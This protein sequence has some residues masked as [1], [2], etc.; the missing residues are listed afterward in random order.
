M[1]DTSFDAQQRFVIRDYDQQPPFASFLPGI[2]G[3]MGIPMWVFYV[4]RGQAIASFGS[5]SKDTPI[6]EFEPAN[7]AYRNVTTTGFRTFVKANGTFYEPFAPAPHTAVERTMHIGANALEL[8]EH[9]HAHG[10][11]VQVR[12]FTLTNEPFAG[13]VRQMQ[14]TNTGAAPVDVSVLDGLPAIMPFGVDNWVLKELART[15][16]AWMGVFNLEERIPFYRLRSSIGDKV[17]I[18]GYEAGHFYT[19]FTAQGRLPALVDPDVIFGPNTSL[20]QPDRFLESSLDELFKREQIAVGKTPCGFFGAER[21]LAPGDALTLYGIIGHASSLA[22]VNQ[23]AARITQPA[24]IVAQHDV[25]Q[26][27]TEELTAPIATQTGLPQFDAY[28]RQTFLDNI[29]RGGWPIRLGDPDR[30][31]VQHIY[32]RKHGDLERDYNAFYLAPEFYSQGN[33]N[34]R[35]INQNRREDVWLQPRIGAYNIRAFMNLIQA[36]G[37]NPLVINGNRFTVPPEHHAAVLAQVDDP[38][39]LEKFLTKPF[40]PGALL[41]FIAVT[42][43]ALRVPPEEFL[44]HTLGHAEHEF[45]AVFGEGYWI[46]HWTYNLDLIENYLAIFPERKTALLFEEPVYTFYDSPGVVQPRDQ[47]YVLSEGRVRQLNAV[48]EDAEKEAL[49]QS[50]QSKPHLVRADQGQGDIVYTTLITKLVSLAI[51]KFATMDPLGM[52]VEMEAGKPGW[53]DALN[54]LPGLFGSS[55][56]ET[57]ELLRLLRF[58]RT[59]LAAQD[60]HTSMT[61]PVEVHDLLRTVQQALA[62]H[63]ASA[64][65]PY[66]DTVATARE[67]YRA[68][69][70]LGFD[71][72]TV[73]MTLTDL[74]HAL[75]QLEQ[76]VQ[77]GIERATTMNDGIPPTYFTYQ[78]TGYE[79]LDDP[80][81]NPDRQCVRVTQFEVRVLPLFLEGP[82]RALKITDDHTAAQQL[83]ER[84]RTS[85]LFDHKL[86]M[87]KVNAPLGDQPTDI[88]RA[89]AFT[90]GWLENESIW[91]HMEY[92]YLLALLKAKLFEAFYADFRNVLVPFQNPT[93]YGRSPL[94]N[95]SFIVSSAHPDGTLHGRGFVARLSGS[96]VEF[97]SILHFILIGPQPFTVCDGALRLTLQPTLPGWLFDDAGE[98]TFTF[99]GG[100]AVTYI[101]PDRRDTFGSEA[102][103]PQQI[104]LQW[105]DGTTMILE[106][107]TIPAPYAEQVRA[108]RAARI[109]IILS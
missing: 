48:I 81:P 34:Y 22:E 28:A 86:K 55:M 91:L 98:L 11:H 92:K 108:E 88:G 44:A 80:Q 82:V 71:G 12:Y 77:L 59:A 74:D 41:K 69:I 97:L 100:T 73:P 30:P 93:T 2:A 54:G 36:D 26:A 102:V 35:D 50:R 47:K 78:A 67:A 31:F 17:E 72:V 89:R 62:H 27:L 46:D 15:A 25:A 75:V 84:V 105:H 3:P 60:P 90:P 16:E 63:T 107:S 66:W 4:N 29:L 10:L 40:T 6:V 106:G 83:H 45:V 5:E 1:H 21:T 43:I 65:T 23:T 109:Q 39:R 99:L 61:L 103:T 94:E 24:Y 37:Y 52:G 70:R 33:G 87:Y 18:E 57:F 51:I 104:T 32:S 68:R 64:D 53:Y 58:L 85:G 42:G 9:A 19:T 101:N 76:K 56:P 95:S 20:S 7:K 14:L 96:T 79:V 8:Q 49:I 13:L 38:T